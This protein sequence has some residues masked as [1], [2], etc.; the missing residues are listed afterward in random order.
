MLYFQASLPGVNLWFLVILKWKR[1]RNSALSI[2]AYPYP[3]MQGASLTQL[4]AASQTEGGGARGAGEVG[5]KQ[6]HTA[7]GEE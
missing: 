2:P 5:G 3:V 1:K 4:P 6:G 7:H